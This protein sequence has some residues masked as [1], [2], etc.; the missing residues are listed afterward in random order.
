MNWKLG[1]I[2]FGIVSITACSGNSKEKSNLT[3]P[4]VS[5]SNADSIHAD[6]MFLMSK[7]NV[8]FESVLDT[9]LPFFAKLHDSIP[10]D[11]RFD[12]VYKEALKVHVKERQVNGLFFKKMDDGTEVYM[13]KRLEP[14][15]KKDK[16]SSLCFTIKRNASGQLDLNTYQEIFWTWKLREAELMR[17][18]AKLFREFVEG[19]DLSQYYPQNSKGY[20]IMFPDERVSYDVKNKKWSSKDDMVNNH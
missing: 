11:K 18:S 14:S 12:P 4:Q 17:K 20:F 13:V 9:V 16:Y 2:A 10:S 15:M 1:L 3:E 8:D 19:K 6:T 5:V 7:Q